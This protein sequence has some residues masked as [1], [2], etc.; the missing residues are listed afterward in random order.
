MPRFA[1]VVVPGCPHHITH[2]GNCRDLVF[3]S[4]EDLSEYLEI[5][6]DYTRLYGVDIWAYCLM[7]NHVHLIAVPEREE[8]FGQAIGR[9]QMKYAR[10]ANRR[11]RWG[12]HL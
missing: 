6:L 2:R 9:A 11:Q 5:L 10:H 4:D 3:F 12:G 7:T 1:R 8:S